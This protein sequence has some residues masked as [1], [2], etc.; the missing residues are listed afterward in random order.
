MSNNI[1]PS[2][3]NLPVELNQI[4]ETSHTYQVNFTIINRGDVRHYPIDIFKK[5]SQCHLTRS[6]LEQ[7][8]FA[9][10][11]IRTNVGCIELP[12]FLENHF[13]E[14]R[15]QNSMWMQGAVSSWCPEDES[16]NF[17]ICFHWLSHCFSQRSLADHNRLNTQ[18]NKMH[19]EEIQYLADTSE[20]NRVRQCLFWLDN[21]SVRLLLFI[22]SSTAEY[23]AQSL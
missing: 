16:S 12:F 11:S 3:V 17:K 9:L 14:S 15:A 6:W 2:L 22:E 23:L 8:I 13:I 4:I 21:S 1:V 10:F 20:I 7:I 5:H 18:R 19:P